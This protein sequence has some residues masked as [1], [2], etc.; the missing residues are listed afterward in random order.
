L[1]QLPDSEFQSPPPIPA[2]RSPLCKQN[3]ST[4]VRR[5]SFVCAASGSPEKCVNMSS[6]DAYG[7]IPDYLPVPPFVH[8]S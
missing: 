5:R 8:S 7:S 6:P 1:T 4:I 3:K 2:R